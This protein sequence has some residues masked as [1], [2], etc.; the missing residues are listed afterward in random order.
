MR[1]V[2]RLEFETSPAVVFGHIHRR[3]AE[4]DAMFNSV[5]RP[6]CAASEA[7]LED[8]SFIKA[9]NEML[10]KPHRIATFA[11]MRANLKADDELDAVRI[12]MGLPKHEHSRSFL[13]ACVLAARVVG[14]EWSS[15]A[16]TTYQKIIRPSENEQVAA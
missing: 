4:L 7:D 11:Q 1:L 5:N 6:Y 15:E 9:F 2:N 16:Y 8:I 12:R 3:Q 14:I 10:T 13:V